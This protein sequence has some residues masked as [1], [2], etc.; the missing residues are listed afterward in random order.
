MHEKYKLYE[1][2]GIEEYWV[3]H[4]SDK[5]LIIF[6]LGADGVYKPSKP[7][8][9]GDLA[10]SSVLPGLAVD[11]SELFMDVVEEPEEGYYPNASR[12]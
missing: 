3:V 1:R 4:P 11:L 8:T 7:L 6:T 2:A 12:L 9:K 5:T 10:N